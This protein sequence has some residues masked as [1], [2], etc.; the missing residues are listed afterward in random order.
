MKYLYTLLLLL[1][2]GC[3][4]TITEPY[5]SSDIINVGYSE[6][7]NYWQPKHIKIKNSTK[8]TRAKIV[9]KGSVILI[10]QYVIDSNGNTQNINLLKSIPAGVASNEDLI[11]SMYIYNKWKKSESNHSVQP[12]KVTER[13]V[14]MP[15]G[16]II[17]PPDD[18]DI[19]DFVKS[20]SAKR[21]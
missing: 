3:R 6:K 13:L 20:L 12:V 5:Y 10:Y 14:L 19:S 2:V 16:N 4:S 21:K 15:N 17:V 7:L 9:S 11:N 1:I 18:M 8:K